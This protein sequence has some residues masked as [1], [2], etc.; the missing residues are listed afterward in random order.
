[1]SSLHYETHRPDYSTVPADLEQKVC[2]CSGH[3]DGY[4]RAVIHPDMTYNYYDKNRPPVGGFEWWVCGTCLKPAPMNALNARLIREC[5]MCEDSYF[6][7]FWPD[8]MNLC[9]GCE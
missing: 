3:K 7:R 1:M 8:R 4:M 2:R 6:V 5:E 9:E